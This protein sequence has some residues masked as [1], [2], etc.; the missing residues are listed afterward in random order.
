MSSYPFF[1]MQ[2][3]FTLEIEKG[4]LNGYGPIKTVVEYATLTFFILI[5]CNICCCMVLL[6][7]SHRTLSKIS[8]Y[9]EKLDNNSD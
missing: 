3:K 9:F 8:I 2:L 7:T 6:Y 1:S 4:G 5:S